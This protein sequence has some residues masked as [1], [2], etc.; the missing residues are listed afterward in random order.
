MLDHAI[1]TNNIGILRLSFWGAISHIN[2]E[3]MPHSKKAKYGRYLL[4]NNIASDS[5]LVLMNYISNI[6]EFISSFTLVKTLYTL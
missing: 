3:Y 5:E 2:N 4:N 1:H 6:S